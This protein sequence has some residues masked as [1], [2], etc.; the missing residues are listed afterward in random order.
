MQERIGRFDVTGTR[1]EVRLV[2]TTLDR[3]SYD[4]RKLRGDVEIRFRP[5]AD[6]PPVPSTGKPALAFCRSARRLLLINSAA[7][8]KT[9]RSVLV[10]EIGHLVDHDRL[11]G[12]RRAEL[13]ALMHRPGSNWR[14]G[15]YQQRACECFAETFVRAFSDVRSSLEGYYARHVADDKLPRFREIVL[16]DADTAPGPDDDDSEEEEPE[17]DA[18]ETAALPD[19]DDV[20]TPAARIPVHIVPNQT[21]TI[22]DKTPFLHP[23]SGIRITTANGTQTFNLVGRTLDGRFRF[24]MIRTGKLVDGETI[25]ALLMVPADRVSNIQPPDED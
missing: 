24:A 5:P 12:P 19:D 10:H 15:G 13:M 6:M 25:R 16:R 22:A 14:S 11:R 17:I 18:D 4:F 2:R 20:E 1:D 9:Q 21:G 7:R 23:E 3:C 8:K